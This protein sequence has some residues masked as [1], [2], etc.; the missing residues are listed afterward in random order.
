MGISKKMKL[1]EEANKRI[2]NDEYGG[3]TFELPPNHLAGMRV[4]KGGS[5]CASCI[6]LSE[7]GAHCRNKYFIKWN[8]GDPKLPYPAEEYCSDWYEPRR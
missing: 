6:W 1:I 5:S 8:G 7:D 2:I 3:D 4:P